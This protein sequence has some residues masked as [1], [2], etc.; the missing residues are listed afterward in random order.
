[1]RQPCLLCDGEAAVCCTDNDDTCMQRDLEH[2]VT[3]S[4]DGHLAVWDIRS[5]GGHRPDLSFRWLAS[6]H[7]AGGNSTTCTTGAAQLCGGSGRGDASPG[8]ACEPCG[9]ADA[10][11]AECMGERGAAVCADATGRQTACGHGAPHAPNSPRGRDAAAALTAGT[12][13]SVPRSTA[14]DSDHVPAA[15]GAPA[16]TAV[17]TGAAC[18][19]ATPLAAGRLPETQPAAARQHTEGAMGTAEASGVRAASGSGAVGRVGEG[20][21]Q[22][23]PVVGSGS[24]AAPAGRT[25][26]KFVS[27][28]SGSGEAGGPG[29]EQ[30]TGGSGS[31]RV[32][33]AAGGR[34]GSG[35]GEAGG[36]KTLAAGLARRTGVVPMP[37]L[38]REVRCVCFQLGGRL[39]CS[40]GAD[41]LVRVR[42]VLRAAAQPARSMEAVDTCMCRHG[43]RSRPVSMSR[44]P[45]C[46]CCAC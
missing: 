18:P 42:R 23:A 19:P 34:R 38:R 20:G 26:R 21:A 10:A 5:G 41:A 40:G 16:V 8:A 9:S 2:L 24:A 39:L 11:E 15:G 46:A 1:M 36:R 30:G 43:R 3:G 33:E 17:A 29:G 13:H 27:F 37:A 45:C 6:G 35:Q 32:R 14:T 25:L 4:Y 44:V 22:E 12:A 7:R 31:M 28:A